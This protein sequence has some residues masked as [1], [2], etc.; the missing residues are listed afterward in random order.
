MPDIG[1]LQANGRFKVTPE[2][3]ERDR[4]GATEELARV[5]GADLSW[6]IGFDFELAHRI[7]F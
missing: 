7:L 2:Y 6:L 3:Q 5:K 1:R 4:I